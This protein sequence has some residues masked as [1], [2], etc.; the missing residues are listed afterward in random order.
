MTDFRKYFHMVNVE[1][2]AFVTFNKVILPHVLCCDIITVYQ[3]LPQISVI[4]F[5]VIT[6]CKYAFRA[7]NMLKE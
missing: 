2:I 6:I 1:Y 5:V 3:V 4:E 7:T